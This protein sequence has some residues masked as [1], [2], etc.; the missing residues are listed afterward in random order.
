MS[1]FDASAPHI[2]NMYAA[3]RFVKSTHFRRLPKTF[4]EQ[5]YVL[6]NSYAR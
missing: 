4:I 2:R 1:V 3:V 5:L 6:G